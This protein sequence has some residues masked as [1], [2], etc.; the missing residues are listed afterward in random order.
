MTKTTSYR[1]GVY[2]EYLAAA[3]LWAKG[4]D[5]LAR[6]YKTKMGEIDLIALKKDVLV[7]AEVKWRADNDSAAGAVMPSSRLRIENAAR[8]YLSQGAYSDVSPRF[9]IIAISPPFFIR[10]ID[11]AWRPAT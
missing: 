9:D 7:F 5:I 4:Y 1:S 2:A 11:N 3:Y 8:L 10:H 6:R